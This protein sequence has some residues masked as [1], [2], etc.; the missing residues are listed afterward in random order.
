MKPDH[1][2]DTSTSQNSHNTSEVSYS[3]CLEIKTQFTFLISNQTPLFFSACVEKRHMIGEKTW[4][5]ITLL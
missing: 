3:V 2:T 1:V 5:S 4:N